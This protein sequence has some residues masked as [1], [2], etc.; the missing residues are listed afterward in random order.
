M[1]ESRST[2][3]L[4]NLQEMLDA[5]AASTRHTLMKGQAQYNTPAWFARQMASMLPRGCALVFDPQAGTGNLIDAASGDYGALKFGVD[6]DRRLAKEGSNGIIRLTASCVDFWRVLDELF[7]RL[8]FRCQVANPPFGIKWRGATANQPEDSTAYT[9]R[10]LIDRAGG[11]GVG[12]MIA[13]KTTIEQLKLH[14]HARAYLYQTFPVGIFDADVEI[15]VLHFSG[16]H[17]DGPDTITHQS[18]DPES[19][20]RICERYD[21]SAFGYY[22]DGSAGGDVLEAFKVIA[23]ALAEEKR[24]QPPYNIYLDPRGYLK[25][26]LSVRHRIARK[27]KK[28]DIEKLAKIG[29][30]HPL[31]L[32]TERDTRMLMA[33]LVECGVYTVQPEAKAAIQSALAEMAAIAC[34]IMP[35]TDF[36]RVAYADENESLEAIGDGDFSRSIWMTRG[37]RYPI[38]TG[39]YTFTHA[40]KRLRMHLDASER[41][42]YTAEHDMTLSGQDR[43][44]EFTDDVGNKHRFMDR[45]NAAAP[46]SKTARIRPAHSEHSDEILWQLF[47]KPEVVTVAEKYPQLVA[48]NCAVMEAC[49]LLAGF[50][51]YPGQRGFYS[52]VAV[53]DYALVGAAT[54]TGKTLGAITL[55][56]LKAPT[57]ALIV[58]PQGTTKG[59][60][61]DDEDEVDDL[62]ASQWIKELRRFAPGLQVFELF[63][64]SD[65]HRIL[66]LNGGELPHGVYVTYYEAM[67]SNGARESASDSY[68]DYKLMRDIGAKLP[69]FKDSIGGDVD[70]YTVGIGEEHKG[71]RCIVRPCMA[72]LIGHLFD[73][74]ALDEA[75]KAQ[76]MSSNVT[77]MIIRLQ[78]RYRYAL[79]ATPIPNL[80]TDIF[81]LMGWLCVP[82]WF[83]GGVRNAA[84]PYARGEGH[85]FSTTFL[86]TERD[87][88][89]EQMNREA[90]PR[91]RGKCEKVSPV[92]SS[93]ARL[94]KLITPTMAFISKEACNPNK[95]KVTVHDV[96]VPMGAQQAKLYGYFMNRANIPESNPKVRAAKQVAILRDLCAAPA[97]SRWNKVQDKL[98]RSNFNSKAAAILSI[99]RDVL[100]RKDQVVIVCARLKQTDMLEKLLAQAGI[101]VSRIDSSLPPDRHSEQANLFKSGATA[102]MLM[103]IKC[104]QAH[105]FDQCP[106]LI[107]ASLEYTW[108]AFDQASGRID[109]V[110][111][112]RPMNIWCVLHENSYE[113]IMFDTVVTKGDAATICLRGERVP[114]TFKSADLGEVLALNFEKFSA[115]KTQR[116][117]ESTIEAGWPQLCESLRAAIAEHPC[118]LARNG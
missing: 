52:R 7:P 80:A 32:T 54:G 91:W 53:R 90:D 45:P 96:R 44:I 114:R 42:T 115:D 111:S 19:V 60:K 71:I 107:V 30:A 40:Y 113:E 8:T 15:G 9:W 64:M 49:E 21:A 16:E 68:D 92:I 79:T 6:I 75:H 3:P 38:T 2:I 59:Q 67:F 37:K 35:I 61:Q 95:P 118:Q 57:R 87:L 97:S 39:T 24:D 17:Q 50:E 105:S 89:Q 58:A 93:P 18:S 26:Y 12:F 36:Q 84:W 5:S 29:G 10:K 14:E 100:L 98:V 83:R 73:F 47:K 20:R 13:S 85:R 11:S 27:L 72:T 70:T 77:Q 116:A 109:R 86:T 104:A 94:L 55:V 117:D 62:Q 66:A 76:R 99:A 33:E 1:I 82:G 78:P 112:K 43:Y 51:Y 81:P 48:K 102:V 4:E 74:I 69:V 63:N 46:D 28:D 88:T 22:A 34:P 31:T 106:N 103:G 108:G 41:E 56:A 101:P 25:T 110:T 23:E 65:Y